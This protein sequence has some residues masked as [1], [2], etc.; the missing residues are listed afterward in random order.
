MGSPRLNVQNDDFFDILNDLVVTS[1]TE[2]TVF[3][4]GDFNARVGKRD[5]FLVDFEASKLIF[6]YEGP[7]SPEIEPRT[8]ED[9][10]SNQRGSDLISFC[11]ASDYLIANGR[12]GRDSSVGRFTCHQRGGTGASAVDYLLFPMESRG[13]IADFSVDIWNHL[14]SDHC[15]LNFELQIPTVDAGQ[16]ETLEL[17]DLDHDFLWKPEFAENFR[18]SMRAKL[19]EIE[20][21]LENISERVADSDSVNL[22]VKE[23][24]ELIY[25]CA[26]PFFTRRKKITTQEDQSVWWTEECQQS[27]TCYYAALR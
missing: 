20:L 21:L 12:I 17:K 18:D 11:R 22:A 8:A 1:R 26:E 14:F 7:E 2:G 16:E 13:I 4:C 23:F 5:E 3:V 15:P 9:V 10:I 6:D 24:L 19:P 27:K 25:S